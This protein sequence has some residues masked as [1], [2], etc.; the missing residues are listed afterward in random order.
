M[1]V[2]LAARVVPVMRVAFRV[3]AGP[4]IG[5]GHWMRSLALAR[6]LRGRDADVS[7]V[8]RHPSPELATL[9]APLG[10][11]LDR[12][13]PSTNPLGTKP[14]SPAHAA[15]LAADPIDDA[16]ATLAAVAR[17]FG[18]ADWLIVDHYGI[19]ARWHDAV[20]GAARALMAIDDL[21]DRALAVDLVLDQGYRHDGTDY[22]RRM[23]LRVP[24]LPG[25]G[26]ALLREDFAQIREDALSRRARLAPVERVLISF[27]GVDAANHAQA[28]LRVLSETPSPQ[29]A[30][31][32]VIGP[33]AVNGDALER[34][35]DDHP[36]RVSIVRA[37]SDM[38]RRM[39][40]ADV[41]FG[42]CGF[43]A[44]ERCC[45]GLPTIAVVAADNQRDAAAALMR[46]GAACVVKPEEDL[47]AAL[48][49]NWARLR[50]DA[51][52][53]R[54]M[55][56]AAA[57]ACDGRGARRVVDAMSRRLP[58]GVSDA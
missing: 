24:V 19:D 46:T 40:L 9:L 58:E 43:T 18:R 33:A 6:V 37:A 2:P 48:A 11:A 30:I 52:L 31:D 16:R 22:D 35:A 53:R 27:G 26:H 4:V 13:P 50:G 5:T 32:L 44:W 3:D 7:F 15:W 45:L 54:R 25:V 47:G 38:A 8:S 51:D 20:R 41:A 21:A 55:S 39:A 42:A 49:A 12:L 56:Q 23:S 17:R 28:A 10:I 14:E 34:Q 29:L 1:P 36:H 57:A